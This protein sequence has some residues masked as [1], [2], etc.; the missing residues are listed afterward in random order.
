MPKA[1]VGFTFCTV[2]VCNDVTFDA[3]Y[4]D[5]VLYLSNLGNVPIFEVK[6]KIVKGGDFQTS[7]LEEIIDWPESGL[8]QGTVLSANIG[9]SFS[10]ANEVTLIPVLRGTSERG[11]QKHTCDEQYGKRII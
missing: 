1:A 2:Y 6:A 11:Q 8:S 4:S 5:G 7:G 3:S 9:S 10:N